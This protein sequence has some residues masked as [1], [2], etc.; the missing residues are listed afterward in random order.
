MIERADPERRADI[1]HEWAKSSITLA[2][3]YR[4]EIIR[5]YRWNWTIRSV[6]FLAGFL[7]A[8]LVMK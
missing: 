7:L 5:I 6:L 2:E 3:G 1:L 8:Y 4:N